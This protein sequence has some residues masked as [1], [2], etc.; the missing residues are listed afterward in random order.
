MSCF[1]FPL[2]LPPYQIEE[3]SLEVQQLKLCTPAAGAMGSIPDRGTK[4]PH[5]AEQLSPSATTTKPLLWSQTLQL[6]KSVLLRAR[7]LQQGEP[8]Q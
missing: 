2:F 5:V 7:A 1:F 3:T 6:L 8:P 4:I